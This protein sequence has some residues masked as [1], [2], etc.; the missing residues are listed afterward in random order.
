LAELYWELIVS[1]TTTTGK[2]LRW[3]LTLEQFTGKV[4]DIVRFLQDRPESRDGVVRKKTPV[5]SKLPEQQRW[6]LAAEG[7]LR[8]T[9]HL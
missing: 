3:S 1:S 7:H 4:A 5:W 8:N 9:G 2:R 6:Q